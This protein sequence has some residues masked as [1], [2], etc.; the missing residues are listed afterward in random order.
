MCIRDRANNLALFGTAY[1]KKRR[2]TKIVTTSVEHSS[3]MENIIS[4]IDRAM[5]ASRNFMLDPNAVP[6]ARSP[7]MML[8]I[9]KHVNW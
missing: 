5:R 8:M 1:A 3:I 7:T 2:G 9:R 6:V 4:P